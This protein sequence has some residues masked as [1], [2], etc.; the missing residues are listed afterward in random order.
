MRVRLRHERLAQALAESP[1]TLNRWAQRMGLRSG[2]LSQLANGKRLYPTARTRQKILD[3]LGLD[4][5]ELF[6]VETPPPAPVESETPD[7]RPFSDLG[8]PQPRPRDPV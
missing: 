8:A 6:V 4:F 2:H 5:D 3:A 1:V 7:P